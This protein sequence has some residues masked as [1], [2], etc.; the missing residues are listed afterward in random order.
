MKTEKQNLSKK[1]QENIYRSKK[2]VVI[3][4]DS[5]PS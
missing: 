5:Q 1:E 3:A 2:V 4:D